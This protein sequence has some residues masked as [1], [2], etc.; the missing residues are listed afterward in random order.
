MRVELASGRA[1]WE[2][3]SSL[4]QEGSATDVNQAVG[5]VRL[6]YRDLHEP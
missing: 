5:S 3:L 1:L 2:A 4:F 6:S